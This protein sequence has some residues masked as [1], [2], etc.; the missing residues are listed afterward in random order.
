[1]SS[2]LNFLKMQVPDRFLGKKAVS[3]VISVVLVVLMGVALAGTA[4]MWGIPMILKRQDTTKV[5]RVYTYFERSNSNSL[6]RKIEFIAKNGGE[7]TFTPDTTGLW[8]LREYDAGEETANSIEFTTFGKVSNIAIS[9]PAT[10]IEWVAL[11]PGGS[12]PPESGLVGF[13]PPYVVCAKAEA[14]S[15]G[16]NVIYRIWFREI[17]ESTGVKGYK[18]N[19]IKHPSGQLSSSARGVRISRGDVSSVVQDGKTLIITEIKIL[20]V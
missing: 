18:I 13:D 12:C 15:D 16:F 4:Y 14:F 8:T 2:F 9:N 17:Y 3:E 7:D 19:L 11:T 20:L 10:G 6:V 1:M 5:E